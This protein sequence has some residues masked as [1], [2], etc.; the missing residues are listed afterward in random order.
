MP[1]F[2]LLCLVTLCIETGVSCVS[3][4]HR[5]QTQPSVS[6]ETVLVKS[7]IYHSHVVVSVVVPDYISCLGFGKYKERCS[8]TL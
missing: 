1:S 6:N 7:T 4:V 5:D 2:S 8:T 3:S